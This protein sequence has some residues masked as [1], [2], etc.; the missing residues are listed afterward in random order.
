MGLRRSLQASVAAVNRGHYFENV[1]HGS[2]L[3]KPNASG[4]ESAGDDSICLVT[5][6]AKAF[7]WLFGP[8]NRGISIEGE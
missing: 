4:D 2:G 6:N 3:V 1:R 7:S 5:S 8:S